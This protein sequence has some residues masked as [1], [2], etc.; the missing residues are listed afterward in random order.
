M[1]KLYSIITEKMINESLISAEE[2][3]IYSF[4]LYLFTIKTLHIFIILVTGFLTNIV[5]QTIIFIVLFKYLRSYCGGWH[6]KKASVC[7]FISWLLIML[8]K[9][10]INMSAYINDAVFFVCVIIACVVIYRFSPIISENNPLE[11]YEKKEY[12][13]KTKTII[14]LYMIIY[15]FSQHLGIYLLAIP[16]SYVVIICAF[17]IIMMIYI[18]SNKKGLR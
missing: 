11:E 5:Y 17:F 3:E 2:K 8:L 16:L 1:S 6:A 18:S 12:S 10:Y 14:V 9:I 13:K 4:G 7:L 15:I